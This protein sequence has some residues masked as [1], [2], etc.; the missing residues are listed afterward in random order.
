MSTRTSKLFNEPG[1]FAHRPDYSSGLSFSVAG[2]QYL[3]RN[4]VRAAAPNVVLT[5]TASTVNYV[6]CSAAGVISTNTTGFTTDAAPLFKV[7][8]GA[9]GVTDV[10][11]VRFSSVSGGLGIVVP[12]TSLRGAT[13]LILTATEVAGGFNLAVATNVLTAQAEITD[14]ETEASVCVASIVLPQNY[15]AGSPITV[16]LP[17]AIVKTGSPTDNGSTIDLEVYKQASGAV[18]SD[19]CAT[20]AQ[21]FA[22]LD[23]WYNK[24]FSVTATGLAAGDVLQLKI[25]SSIIDSEAGAGTMRLNMDAVKV[26]MDL[27]A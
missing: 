5:L 3:N 24:D 6:E 20:A 27:A 13:G 4:N 8:T 10:T 1:A 16:R 12:V 22:A 18:G 23:T 19:L 21:T 7:T 14:N 25:T 2:G 15:V 9:S 26:Y 17:V 11:D